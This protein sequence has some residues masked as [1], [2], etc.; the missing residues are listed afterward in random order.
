MQSRSVSKTIPFDCTKV[1]IKIVDKSQLDEA[2]LRKLYRE[3]QVLKLLQHDHIIRL[4]QVN[5]QP[6]DDITTR[7]PLEAFKSSSQLIDHVTCV[8][9]FSFVFLP[10]PV[11]TTCPF[12]DPMSTSA[13]CWCRL[14]VFT[15][16]MHVDE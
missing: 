2:N 10:N 16:I 1:A 6:P 5:T 8:V 3:V 11:T 7:C 4:Y 15:W 13:F 9:L 12:P 14:T